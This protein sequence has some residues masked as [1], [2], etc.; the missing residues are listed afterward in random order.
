MEILLEN[1]IDRVL[2]ALGQLGLAESTIQSYATS[3]YGPMRTYCA[4]HETTGYEPTVLNAFLMTQKDRLARSEISPRHFRKLRRAVLMIHDLHEHETLQE[5]RYDSG[6]PYPVSDYFHRCLNLFIEAQT[7]SQ[8]TLAGLKSL[9]VQFLCHLERT[10]HRDFRAL[11][12]GDVED[13]LQRAAETHQASMSNVVG[14]L[15]LFLDYLRSQAWVSK[16]FRPLLS[17]PARRKKRLLPCF[18]VAE[19][20]A[21]LGQIDTRTNQGKR[22]YAILLLASHT[23]MRSIDIVNLRRAHLDWRT[24]SI[25]IVQRKTGQPLALPLEPDTGNAIAQYLLD[26]RP[27]STA[28]YVFLRTRAPYRKLA[29]QGSLDNILNKYLQHAGIVRQPG[30]GKSFHALRRSMA[31]WMLDSGVPLTTISQVLGHKAQESAKPYLSMD[32]ARLASCARD[33]REVPLGRGIFPW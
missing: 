23:G 30:D 18:S 14:A 29:D 33:F 7:V 20:E 5:A 19:V 3:A 27:P 16:D 6:S 9:V 8:G 31:T 4:S 12:A 10:G 25:H 21:I 1:L 13:F 26:A 32:Y 28:D 11:S 15:R 2:G 17:R 24:H 22:D